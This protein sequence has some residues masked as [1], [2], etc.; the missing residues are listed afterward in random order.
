MKK[1]LCFLFCLCMIASFCK[2][3]QIQAGIKAGVSIPNLSSSGDNPVSSGWSSRLG[4]YFGAIVQFGINDRISIQAELNYSSQGGKKNG[5]QAISSKPYASYFPPG[6]QVPKYFYAVYD[7]KVK[8]NYLELPVLLKFDFPFAE[9]FSFFVDGGPYA[10]YLLSAKSVTSGSGNV[11]ADK[12]LTQPY[13][14]SAVSFDASTDVKEDI[15]KFNAGIQGGIGLSLRFAN[16]SK[17]IFSA[18]G[19][20]GFIPIQKD[21][22]NGK[23][24]TGAAT[25]TFGYVVNL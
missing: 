18:G 7:N 3:Q 25:V 24:N 19:N 23:N 1:K 12:D 15:K 16:E 13:L 5:L 8:L 6:S 9:K 4:S 11:Y 17:L 2:A 22:A 14:P 20:Y 21:E 10:G